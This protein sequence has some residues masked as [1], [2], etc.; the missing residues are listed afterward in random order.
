VL[1]RVAGIGEPAMNHVITVT[2]RRLDQGLGEV[3][4]PVTIIPRVTLDLAPGRF[5]WPQDLRERPFTVTVE[6]AARDSTL[7]SVRL[8]VPDGW[9]VDAARTLQFTREGERR[10]LTFHVRAPARPPAGEIDLLAEAAIGAD[11]LRLGSRRIGYPHLRERVVF[12][13]A[14]ATAMVA[15]VRFPR[16]LAIGYIR[17]AADLIPEALG[18]AGLPFR[19][20]HSDELDGAALDSLD[21]LVVG[22]RA[23]EIDDALRRAHPRLI[24]FA[25]RGGTLIIQYQQY[26]FIEGGFAPL[27]MTI[28][29]PHD[30]V[31]D[32][33]APVRFLDPSHPVAS[34][35]NR[36]TP[37]DFDGWTQERGLYFAREWDERLTPILETQ[38]PDQPPQRG[39]L[40]VGRLGE[41]TVVYTGIAFFRQLP[42]AV[43]GAW[44]LFANLLAIGGDG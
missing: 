34:R 11:T 43:P 12:H 4:N 7:A 21:V 28:A 42:A 32:E 10:T 19:L 18:A 27:P 2:A 30:R 39:A 9:Q 16:D 40:L 17:G 3:R 24:R 15:P 35:P 5:L 33:T 25:E 23:Y 8:V 31:T 14:D 13:L 22:P 20:L 1:A 38:D 37:A 36:L 6:H 26:Q 44:R 41:G 29:R